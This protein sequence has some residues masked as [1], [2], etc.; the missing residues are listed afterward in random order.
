MKLT[1]IKQIKNIGTYKNSGN[2]RIELKPFTFIYASNTYG[3]TTFCDIMRSLKTNDI[4]YINNRRRIGIKDSE[5]CLVS[6]LIDKNNVD[7]DGEKWLISDGVDIREHLEIF[8]INFVNEN[9]FT[10]FK[11][12]HKNKESFT[13]FI[14]GE[15]GVDLVK[16]LEDL[17][18]ALS[19]KEQ[20]FKENKPKLEKLLKGIFFDDIKKQP[21]NEK[22]KDI[23][24][25]L[26][27]SNEEIQK[28]TKQLSEIDKI[29]GIKKIEAIFVDYS[30]LRKLINDV[31]DIC[32]I[33]Y[34]IDL[35]KL[36][37]SIENIK[38]ETHGIT[39]QWLKE[40][41]KLS[42]DKCPLC[43]ATIQNNERI[44]IFSE[45]FSE[46]IIS[47]LDKIEKCQRNIITTF[48]GAD[49]SS[50]LIKCTQ[51]KNLIVPYYNSDASLLDSLNILIDQ[52]AYKAN[53]IGEKIENAKDEL[54]KNLSMKLAS[55]NRT[56]FNFNESNILFT[57]L[58]EI[59]SLISTLNHQINNVNQT[60]IKYQE[61][62]SSKYLI[63]QISKNKSEY[64]RNNLTFLRGQYNDEIDA[65][66]QVEEHIKELKVK[67]KKTRLE[68]DSQQEE[69]LNK[70]FVA[71]QHI[72]SKLG[73][74][75]YRIERELTPRGKKKVYGVKIYFMNKLIDE[76]RF[77][78]S[79]SDRRALAL[80]VFL[81][82]IKMDDNPN[83]IIILDDPVT[84][85][86]QDRMRNFIG[87]INELKSHCFEQIIIL[88]HYENF[89]KLITKATE[90]KT[91]IK[92]IR[93]RD[94]HIF[95]EIS[96]DDDVFSD[97]YNNALNHII[98][99]INAETNVIK[100][101][102][103][104]IFI[105]KYLHNYYAYEI[106]KKPSLKGGTLHE[107]I[108]NLE[109]EELISTEVKDD[110]Q[111]KLKF[112]NESSHSFTDYSVEEQRSFIKEAY[113][114]LHNL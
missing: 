82:K 111:L 30:V 63:E 5:K 106:S 48:K 93:E 89:F 12:E 53:V 15:R 79:E 92:L 68:I 102:D 99:F 6:L 7:F 33:T 41:I 86:D 2:A 20:K 32:G 94:N 67:I 56:D 27:N 44:K 45:Y 36:K 98:K 61:T 39:D 14:L 38:K 55:V 112:L 96:E 42:K 70:Y 103:I 77:C 110:L 10:N 21:Y 72:Y 26:I 13:S 81:S 46:L 66:I 84:S 4:S 113:L 95:N 64:N 78:M 104:R 9:V 69:F 87:V 3:K 51:Q 25:L 1:R 17:E 85:F 59:D 23:E 105:E 88:M 29:K 24:S 31:K 34:D 109:K 65:L 40:G 107:F 76:T 52:A 80:S 54:E 71:I 58:D 18:K 49:I 57:N 43:G 97:E 101:N 22:F 90:E 28:L 100:E 19:E 8:D 35:R 47:F 60:F 108:I 50:S 11:I 73:G 16:T 91:L 83:S 62:L 74:E 114:S 75:N 37:T